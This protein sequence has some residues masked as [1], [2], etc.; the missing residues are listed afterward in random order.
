M[1]KSELYTYI[2][3][4]AD[5]FTAVSDAIWEYAELSLQEYRS[6]DC[7]EKALKDAGFAVTRGLAGI[8]TAVIGTFGSGHPVIGILGE[9][10]GRIYDEVKQRPLYIEDKK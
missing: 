2:D 8:D 9:Y 3:A 10:I 1:N 6:A 5:R 7:Y 4:N